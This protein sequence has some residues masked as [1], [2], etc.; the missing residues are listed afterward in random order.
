MCHTIR[1]N[2]VNSYIEVF[3]IFGQRECKYTAPLQMG[4]Q[5]KN[6][7]HSIALFQN[8]IR[9][10]HTRENCIVN[11]GYYIYLAEHALHSDQY[12]LLDGNFK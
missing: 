2:T 12:I 8:P 5:E 11:S 6:S 9:K 7:H 1:S 3:Y 10:G 4:C